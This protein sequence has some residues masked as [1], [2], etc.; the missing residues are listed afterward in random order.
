MAAGKAPRTQVRKRF[1]QHFLVD[2]FVVDQIIALIAPNEGDYILEIGPGGGILT[3]PL[4]ASGACVSIVEIDRELAAKLALAFADKPNLTLYAQDVLNLDL[5]VVTASAKPW[6][7]VGNLPY[8]ISTPLILRLLENADLF[9]EMT[10]MLQLEVAQRLAA[11]PGTRA[12][13]RL[14]VMAQRRASITCRLQVDPASFEPP[15][16]VNSAVVQLVPYGRTYEPR[17]EQDFAE[18]VRMAFSQRRK[19]VA[20]ALRTRVDKRTFLDCAIDPG[21]RA[22]TLSISDFERL[23][24]ARHEAGG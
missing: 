4:V 18:I 1:G 9:S 21:S 10:F 8:N 15:P 19:T 17:I 24:Q 14:S 22:E 3:R 16:Q 5:G 6:K 11:T 7:V 12:Y 2:D 13:G 23:A 20:N